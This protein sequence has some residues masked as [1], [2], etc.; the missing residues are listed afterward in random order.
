VQEQLH[1]AAVIGLALVLAL[2]GAGCQ[3]PDPSPPVEQ[4]DA[5]DQLTASL[6][7]ALRQG[8]RDDV[9]ALATSTLAADLDER[10]LVIIARTFAWLGQHATPTRVAEQPIEGGVERRY[11]LSFDRG[12]LEL[13]VTV[14]A[15][16]LEGFAFAEQTWADMV[17]RAAEAA[18]GDLRVTGFAFVDRQGQVLAQPNDPTAI[19]YDL[20][21]EGLA[22]QLREHHV[23]IAKQVFDPQGQQVY[24]Q[25]QDDEASFSQSEP[26]ASGGRISG[27]VAVPSPG[28][29]V[30]ELEIQD[31]IGSTY[32]VHRVPFEVV[33]PPEPPPSKKKKSKK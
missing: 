2:A 10:E 4:T 31:M 23:V 18:A 28:S 20:T 15:D 30:L 27:S 14:I 11:A 19:N 21:L 32:L 8:Q 25:E 3:K 9:L 29:Y 33:L 22:A 12:E 7:V 26:G 5:V 16:E 17:E 13:T 6:L 24:R 1:A